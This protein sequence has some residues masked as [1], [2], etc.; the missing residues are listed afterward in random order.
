MRHY[1]LAR[2]G[3]FNILIKYQESKEKKIICFFKLKMQ[4][5]GGGERERKKE[6]NNHFQSKITYKFVLYEENTGH[7]HQIAP[8]TSKFKKLSLWEGGHP[9][10]H[11]PPT[12]AR[13]ARSGSVAS[14]PRTLF[15]PPPP[16][17]KSWLR[18][19][20]LYVQTFINYINNA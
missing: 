10:G 16:K 7:M 11:P 4:K 20:M 13:Y 9:P 6:E 14:L 18:H 15:L 3:H 2:E 19:C 1:S 17:I 12:L 5:K 8:L